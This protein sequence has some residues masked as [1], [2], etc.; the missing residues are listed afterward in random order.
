MTNSNEKI[1]LGYRHEPEVILSDIL[2][3][4]FDKTKPHYVPQL[5]PS[6]DNPFVKIIVG[7]GELYC[8]FQTEDQIHE[9]ILLEGD[10][11]T[12]EKDVYFQIV[13]RSPADVF[14]GYSSEYQAKLQETQHQ[15]EIIKKLQP[16]FISKVQKEKNVGA[17]KLTHNKRLKTNKGGLNYLVKDGVIYESFDS[18]TKLVVT[19]K[20][21]KCRLI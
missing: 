13:Q 21:S 5:S 9:L 6:D 19:E 10:M 8:I 1:H 4:K 11:V 15:N 16:L 14:I 3:E 20:W 12:I 7:G 17:K 2:H 18:H